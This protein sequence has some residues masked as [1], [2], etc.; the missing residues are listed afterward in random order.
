MAVSRKNRS[1]A[2]AKADKEKDRMA[3]VYRYTLLCRDR[4]DVDRMIR[5]RKL[6]HTFRPEIMAAL[7]AIEREWGID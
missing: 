1:V 4:R 6:G 5:V 2:K 7:D 3:H